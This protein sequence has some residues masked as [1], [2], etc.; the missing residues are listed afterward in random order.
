L[1]SLIEAHVPGH[2]M[3]R[4]ASATLPNRPP[5]GKTQ[6]L[7]GPLS[8]QFLPS[9][10]RR[11]LPSCVEITAVGSGRMC[12]Y[13]PADALGDADLIARSRNRPADAWDVHRQRS[14]RR[15]MNPAATW[16]GSF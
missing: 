1:S 14:C 12:A 5:C 13:R 7:T 16:T 3:A 8:P 10:S 2:S 11:P 9:I 6:A 15:R 4:Q